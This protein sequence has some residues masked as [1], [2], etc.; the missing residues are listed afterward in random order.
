MTRRIGFALSLWAASL[1]AATVE[2]GTF[3]LHKFEQAIGEE[4]YE[5]ARDGDTLTLTSNF[6]FRD[7]GTPVN[8][9]STLRL[10]PDYTPER[11]EIKGK[12]SRFST[13]DTTLTAPVGSGPVFPIPA[14]A[15]LSVQMALVR[16]W[17]QHGRPA[18]I[19]RAPA[20]TLYIEPR[21]RDTVTVQGRSM[22]ADRYTVRGLIWGRE[23]LWLDGDMRLVAAV[24]VDDEMD[25]FEAVR[26]GWED[27]LPFFVRR[28]AEDNMQAL[29]DLSGAMTHSQGG[30]LAITGATLIDGTG[31]PPVHNAV[32]L[33]D[34]GRIRAAGP[35]GKVKIPA[36]S[37][38]FD[39]TGRFVLPGLW[40][41][42]AH[43][44][45]VEWGPL[46]LAAGITTV[47]DCGN[48]FDF[49]TAARAAIDSGR[50]LGPKLLLGGIIDGDG[51][52][53]IGLIRAGNAAQGRAFVNKYR[54][55][56]FDQIKVYSSLKLD[57]L[58]A[59][60]DE[61]HG[62]GL[63]VFGHVPNGMTAFQGVEDGMDGIEHFESYIHPALLGL[64]TKRYG[65][66]PPI[67]LRSEAARSGIA[68][69]RAHHTVIGP[70]MALFEW[71]WHANNT[72]VAA[73]EPGIRHVAP[74]L[75]DAL[76]HSGVP[77]SIAPRYAEML[78]S[79]LAA[80]V[81][82]RRAGVPIIAGTDQTVPGYSLYREL[83]LYVEGGMT[84]LEAIQT[85]T[86]VPARVMKRE[87]EMGSV[88]PGKRADLIVLDADPLADIHNMRTVRYVVAA[89]RLF[90]C[91]P[92]WRAVGFTP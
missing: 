72:P 44:E 1:A 61:A 73:F 56:G 52:M 19:S 41:T 59:I 86:T 80:I 26:E 12:T 76:E 92:L 43:F 65:V 23:T 67:D 5:V 62:H 3:R 68:F 20:G 38:K 89:G 84:P 4:K 9:A 32:I 27:G 69:F 2:S 6:Q 7:R 54:E 16:Y 11:L 40:D 46:Y 64:A 34:G 10:K 78:K 51:P 17:A 87:R 60:T 75:R 39:A 8:L 66:L 28:A 22:A 45:Q 25:H 50:G 14:Y 85:A 24:T 21:G 18:T 88:E 82:L 71:L 48:E 31:R 90:E 83:E 29:A 30:V 53:A 13:I 79:E 74:E 33:V 35:R 91:A 57:V 42:H 58:K 36:G 37:T 81:A 47:R 55:A 49:I 70:T 77:A 15:P 63:T